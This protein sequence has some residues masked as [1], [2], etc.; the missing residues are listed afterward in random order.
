MSFEVAAITPP[1]F[2]SVIAMCTVSPGLPLASPT[3]TAGPVIGDV[4]VALAA[5][6]EVGVAVA[7]TPDVVVGEA[8]A[9]EV[10]VSVAAPRS[11]ERRVGQECRPR[12]SRPCVTGR[13]TGC[14]VAPEA[15]RRCG[16]AVT[17]GR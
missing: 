2:A 4:G 9:A 8:A 13:T 7:P 16:Q 10:G 6:P 3:L 11:E 5:A 14:A 1:L 17:P 15:A 12:G